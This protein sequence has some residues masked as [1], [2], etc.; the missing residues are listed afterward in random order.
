L[1]IDLLDSEIKVHDKVKKK[2]EL[3]KYLT[4]LAVEQVIRQYEESAN[5]LYFAESTSRFLVRRWSW[6]IPSVNNIDRIHHAHVPKFDRTRTVTIEYSKYM[7][8][9]H[10]EHA[11]FGY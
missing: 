2:I 4:E 10:G 11:F 8:N 7:K 3:S 1:D 6:T 5:Y 9:N